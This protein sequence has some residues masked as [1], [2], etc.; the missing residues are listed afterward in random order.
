VKREYDDWVAG[1]TLTPKQTQAARMYA[2][3]HHLPSPDQ[4]SAKGQSDLAALEP[5][6]QEIKD[7]Q[8]RLKSEGLDKADDHRLVADYAKYAHLGLS[9]PHNDLFTSLSF[10]QLRSAAAAMKG[11]NSRAYPI[12]SRALLHTPVLDRGFG[13]LADTPKTM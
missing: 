12:I 7:I 4:M 10:E 13:V 1:R 9:T 11:M 3:E 8:D 5:V 2:T 6:I